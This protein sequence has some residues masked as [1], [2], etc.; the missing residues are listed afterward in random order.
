MYKQ[1]SM[2]CSH[3]IVAM[4]GLWAATTHSGPSATT[5]R[6]A[7]TSPPVV[8]DSLA[9]RGHGARQVLQA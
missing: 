1:E 9:S 4:Y 6:L 7:D 8:H 3:A 2:P 5:L